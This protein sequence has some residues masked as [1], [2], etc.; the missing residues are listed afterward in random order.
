MDGWR[1]REGGREKDG[2]VEGGVDGVG[3]EGWRH[4]QNK[5]TVVLLAAEMAA[6]Q[7]AAVNQVEV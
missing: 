5:L 7:H 3:R 4:R 6:C 2:G 1:Q